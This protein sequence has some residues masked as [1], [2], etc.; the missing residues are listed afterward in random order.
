LKKTIAAVIGLAVFMLV[1]SLAFAQAGAKDVIIMKDAPNGA[2]TF[3]HKKHTTAAGKCEACHHASK[4]EKANKAAQQACRDC[5][6]QPVAAGMKTKRQAAFHN[7][8]ATAGICIDCHKTKAA[9]KAP[10][11]CGECHKKAAA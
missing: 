4:P 7:P 3:D 5:H 9:G 2:V 10:V 6:S 8:A 1:C 11:K